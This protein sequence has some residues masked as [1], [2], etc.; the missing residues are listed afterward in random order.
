[1]KKEV[2]K[3]KKHKN[4]MLLIAI[5]I[6]IVAILGVIIVSQNNN[7]IKGQLDKILSS[8]DLEFIFFEKKGSYES[9]QFKELLDTDLKEQGV[10]YTTIDVTNATSEDLEYI[11]EKLNLSSGEFDLYI[12]AI[13]GSENLA[14]INYNDYDR[15]FFLLANENLLKDSALILNDYYYK[16][17]KE[18]LDNGFLGEAKRNLDNC[19]G[20]LDTNELLS[21]KRFLLLDSDFGYKVENTS[22]INSFYILNFSFNYSSGYLDSDQLHIS[23]IECKGYSCLDPQSESASYDAKVIENIIYIKDSNETD[24]KEY[25]T[26]EEITDDTLKIKEISWTLK[27]E[28]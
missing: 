18:A 28:N 13:K 11:K 19:L 26:I 17:G 21:D 4:K 12:A 27:K 24:Y 8:N 7:S 5:P 23:K 1:M 22:S 3:S 14:L 2:K 16:L 10:S 9:D 6:I 15:T 25:Y 20:Y